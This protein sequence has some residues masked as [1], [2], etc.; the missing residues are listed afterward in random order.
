MSR[1]ISIAT[2]LTV[3][4]VCERLAIRIEP[5]PVGIRLQDFGE[6]NPDTRFFGRI[7]DRR[8]S[9]QPFSSKVSFGEK[10]RGRVSEGAAGGSLITLRATL[11]WAA[12]A[13]LT[14]ATAGA[15]AI[16]LRFWGVVFEGWPGLVA[17]GTICLISFVR[18]RR[19]VR[20]LRP[21][22]IAFL[23]RAVQGIP[24]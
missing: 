3:A 2:D 8:L 14:G 11:P 21:E 4:E 20:T 19:R 15:V 18:W 5:S 7:S 13:W 9:L 22:M 1:S 10:W 17:L 12:R 16:L 23:T 24:P 6:L